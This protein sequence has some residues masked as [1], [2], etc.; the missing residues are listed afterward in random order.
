[1]SKR[2]YHVGHLVL[3]RSFF[4][5]SIRINF[6]RWIFG[7]YVNQKLGLLE[8]VDDRTQGALFPIIKKYISGGTIIHSDSAAMYVNN[9]QQQSPH[10]YSDNSYAPIPTC[11][12]QPYPAL[13]GSAHGGVHK[14]RGGFLEKC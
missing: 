3:E 5:S 4:T 11:V 14:L 7:I 9:A 2:K 10:Q 1:M 8:F 13:C 12:G 6:I